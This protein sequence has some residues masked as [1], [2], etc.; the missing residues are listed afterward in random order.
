M[1]ARETNNFLGP[2]PK[3]GEREN[4]GGKLALIIGNQFLFLTPQPLERWI[5]LM[6]LRRN[7]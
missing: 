4:A 7:S 3:T 6:E 2:T 5:F 1:G